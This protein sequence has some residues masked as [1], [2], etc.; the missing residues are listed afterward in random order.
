MK[1]NPANSRRGITKIEV[2]VVIVVLAILVAMI[3]P[4]LLASRRHA[5]HISCAGVLKQIGLSFKVWA[6]DHDGKYPMQTSITN[7]GTMEL[8]ASGNAFVHFQIMSNELITTKILLCWNDK[9]RTNAISWD[10]LNNQN[11]SYF[12]GVDATPTNSAAFLA[13]DRNLSLNDAPVN[14]GL[15][16]FTPGVIAGWTKQIHNKRGN[17]LLS[18]GS[19]Q[20]WNSARLDAAM[21]HTGMGTNRLA[22][23]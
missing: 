11:V 2:L 7:G 3:L 22:I 5:S 18:D 1:L 6:L 4:A 12:V 23:P 21:K 17:V 16:S 8:I 9:E 20:Q 15:V 10:N 14:P 19:V 13:G